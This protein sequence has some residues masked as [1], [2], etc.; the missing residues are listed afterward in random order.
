MTRRD[1][2]M[3]DR[4]TDANLLSASIRRA[5]ILGQLRQNV[6]IFSQKFGVSHLLADHFTQIMRDNCFVAHSPRQMTV[7]NC[8]SIFNN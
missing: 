1:N 4:T 6:P 7:I 3:I 5:V 8:N 2:D